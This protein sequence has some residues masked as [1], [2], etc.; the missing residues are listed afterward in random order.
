MKWVKGSPIWTDQAPGQ[1]PGQVRVL[2]QYSNLNAKR[3]CSG[4]SKNWARL[5]TTNSFDARSSFKP[6]SSF[7]HH[8]NFI[9]L[10]VRIA[11]SACWKIHQI[12]KMAASHNDRNRN[13]F[14]WLMC[15]YVSYDWLVVLLLL[16]ENMWREE[17]FDPLLLLHNAIQSSFFHTTF[18]TY[19]RYV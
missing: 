3:G 2:H 18:Y 11:T 1:E 19:K 13:S 4:W 12:R 10:V 8:N 17:S 14:V 9:I 7:I 6:S 15:D 16:Q 5:R